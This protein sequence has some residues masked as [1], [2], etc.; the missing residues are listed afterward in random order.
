MKGNLKRP[1]LVLDEEKVKR[2]IRR[3]AEK[4]RRSGV[5][6]RPHFKTHQSAEIGAFFREEGVSAITVSSVDMAMYFAGHGWEDITIAFPVNLLQVDEIKDLAQRVKLNVL[7]E[8]NESVHFLNQHLN[9]DVG[10]WIKIDVGYHRTGIPADRADE[11][12][13]LASKIAESRVLS[14]RGLLTHAGH[15]YHAA[16]PEAVRGIYDETAAKLN[17]VRDILGERGFEGVLISVGDTPACSIV[18][19]FQGVDEIR[20]GNFVFYDVMQMEIGACTVEDVAVAVACPVV[21]KHREREEIVI[22]GGAVHLSKEFVTRADGKTIYG[23]VVSGGEGG[24]GPLIRDTHVSSLSQE[25]GVIKTGRGFFDKTRIGD[26]LMV[27]PVHSCLT[28]DLLREYR[29][30][31]GRIVKA[32]C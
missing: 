14:L 20:P 17:R 32:W 23:L 25:H 8:S 31:D 11:V 18:E 26:I 10:A 15:T 21:A 3:M 13:D 16:S 9:Y 2:N 28:V 24:W 4:A 1:T 27:L 30:P 5:L 7:V 6:F 29:T 12:A 22:Y 19:E